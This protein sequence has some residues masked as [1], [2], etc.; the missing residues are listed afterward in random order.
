MTR[1]VVVGAGPAGIA[2][3]CRAAESGA[4]VTLLDGAPYPG[5]QIWRRGID[6][7]V[8]RKA[9]RWFN[10]LDKVGV[11]LR[12]TE[13]VIDI[14]G[15]SVQVQKEQGG[16][17]SPMPVA[18]QRGEWIAFDKLILATGARELFL[19]FPGWTLPNVMGVGGAQ[20]LLKA[21]MPVKGLRVVVGGSGPLLFA[22]AASL[23]KAGAKIV[24]VAEQT[25]RVQLAKFA[26]GTLRY[27]PAKLVQGIGYM[28]QYFPAP[29]W[30]NTWV[31]EARGDSQVRE[32][33]L[34]N[35][36][37]EWIEPADIVAC[38]YGLVPNV[39]L[40]ALAGC[41]QENGRLVVDH[42]Q[43]CHGHPGRVGTGW[44]PVSRFFAAG[45]I[46]GIGGTE[47]AITEGE[48]AGLTAAGKEQSAAKLIAR[49][50]RQQKFARLL[51]QSFAL[52][53]QLKSALAD[54]P[55]DT[56]VCRCEDVTF[57]ELKNQADQR[58]AKLYTRCG[59]GPCQGR[60][61]SSAL[62]YLLDWEPNK[63]RPPLFPTKI[64]DFIS[65]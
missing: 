49:R 60:V 19:P 40:A 25:S 21:G 18:T 41:K 10:R 4:I 23:A 61:C 37:R 30:P 48:I 63:V 7:S 65:K 20:A 50:E 8:P 9:K 16:L 42:L 59:M 36:K 22:V 5:G 15:S 27:E 13:T 64:G 58:S 31:K 2:A 43:R 55:D 1:I 62:Q 6:Y 12:T 17:D 52:K 47:L 32:V 45:E 26:L 57:G 35:G 38:A 46:T 28:L 3:A 56:I 53:P 54:L 39:E 51:N 24:C 44:K 34:T 11:S 29:Y 14:M 33:I